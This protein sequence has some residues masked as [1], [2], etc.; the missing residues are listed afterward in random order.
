MERGTVAEVAALV[1]P[2]VVQIEMVGSVGSGVIWRDDGYIMTAAHVIVDPEA[3]VT[4]RLADG[5]ELNG[6][7]VG[8]NEA[9]DVAVVKVDDGVLPVAEL[10]R[11]RLL[12]I[13]EPAI[14]LGSP[15]GFD[16]SVTSGIVSAVD[17]LVDGV[18]MVQ[19]DAAINPGNSGGP[20]LDETGAVIGINDAI[21]SQTGSSDGVGFAIAIDL[22]VNV[23]EQI[24]SGEDVEVAFLGVFV[25]GEVG[26]VPGA[27]LAEVEV[28]SPADGAGLLAGD[29]VVSFDGE[30]VTN[31]DALGAKILKRRPGFQVA[32][33]IYRDGET[34]V[35]D[36]GLGSVVR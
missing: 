22:A 21:F 18:A 34:L 2:A 7:V 8:T 9:I 30:V 3:T 12:D 10:A 26:A 27:L 15:F 20:L 17:R 13:G 6:E 19:T 1:G 35:L 16:Q 4:V 14:A 11:G 5:R 24:V 31:R 23:A 36:L 25:S 32:I 33:E 28:G 29:I